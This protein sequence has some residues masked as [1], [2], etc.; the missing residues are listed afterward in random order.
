MR[1]ILIA[2]SFCITI[3]YSDEWIKLKPS[4]MIELR[5]SMLHNYV[6]RNDV[7]TALRRL[8]IPDGRI[9]SDRESNYDYYYNVIK[10]LVSKDLLVK[11]L[12]FLAQD[13][14]YKEEKY[15]Y[16]FAKKWISYLAN[17][18]NNTQKNEANYI[19]EKFLR[20]KYD[21][22]KSVKW[23][24]QGYQCVQS[25]GQVRTPSQEG[26][27]FLITDDLIVTNHHV[28]SSTNIAKKSQIVFDYYQNIDGSIQ[29]APPIN[30]N[31]DKAFFV[32]RNGDI[33]FSIVAL[34]NKQSRYVPKIKEKIDKQTPIY[35][36]QHAQGNDLQISINNNQIRNITKN[37]VKYTTPTK[38]GSSGSPV[39]DHNWNVIAVH[40]GSQKGRNAGTRISKI[41][42]ILK[43]NSDPN[44]KRIYHKIIKYHQS[45]IVKIVPE[46]IKRDFDK[47][48]NKNIIPI[49]KRR[50]IKDLL[51]E[52]AE[53]VAQQIDEES[54]TTSLKATKI[55]KYKITKSKNFL[56]YCMNVVDYLH[57]KGKLEKW[58]KYLIKDEN[59]FAKE[60]YDKLYK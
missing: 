14:F 37:S 27:G 10:H 59:E 21:I 30:L 52:F 41:L 7:N 4:K 39:F 2:L 35:V 49:K 25:I 40:W 6:Q 50:N 24:Q 8:D 16:V 20:P 56:E 17:A 28:I 42:H 12:F 33:D 38:Q 44:A 34:Q 3:I 26:T 45:K 43:K 46:T 53:I 13:P 29:E 48:D 9:G 11:W 54:L 57:T 19:R 51:P 1:K 58:L 18:E 32:A 5:D 22:L 47:T 36:M 15:G 55:K 23:L 60:W 31:P